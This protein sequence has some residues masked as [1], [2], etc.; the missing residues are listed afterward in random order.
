MVFCTVNDNID[1]WIRYHRVSKKIII[2]YEIIRSF[3][4]N[5][6]GI[7]FYYQYQYVERIIPSEL[8]NRYSK[9]INF[10]TVQARHKKIADPWR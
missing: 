7:Y 10:I 5:L 6:I 2:I 3:R 9:R 1:E 4:V 8:I